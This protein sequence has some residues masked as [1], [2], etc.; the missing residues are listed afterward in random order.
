MSLKVYGTLRAK[1]SAAPVSTG[2]PVAVAADPAAHV[3]AI[4]RS[5]RELQIAQAKLAQA[6][7]EAEEL[8]RAKADADAERDRTIIR[9]S[10][11]SAA[12][13]AR[14]LNPDHVFA[15]KSQDFVLHNGKVVS[16]SD[17]SKDADA[18]LAEFFGSE[19]KY[20]LAPSVPGGSGAPGVQSITQ[21][22]PADLTSKAGL[23][24]L[25]RGITHQLFG[26]KPAGA[27]KP[28]E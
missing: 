8:K 2:Q 11:L 23:T 25:T 15:L 10:L 16:K 22:P 5:A 19:G 9:N 27:P 18:A 6:Q 1:Q 21:A 17:P 4:Q 26:T 20:L 14:A 28:T 3:E 7:R 24:A 12:A 13:K